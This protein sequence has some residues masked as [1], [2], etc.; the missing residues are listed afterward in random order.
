M[1]FELIGASELKDLEFVFE[2][3]VGRF[4]DWQIT[5]SGPVSWLGEREIANGGLLAYPSAVARCPT[6]IPHHPH[7]LAD[8]ERLL[9]AS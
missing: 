7:P 5:L 6:A 3:K 8:A 2:L 9:W 4:P 1:P